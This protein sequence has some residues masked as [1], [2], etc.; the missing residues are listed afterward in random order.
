M[1]PININDLN[2]AQQDVEHIAE[3]A[4]SSATTATDRLG[5]SKQTIS[6]LIAS[7][8]VSVESAAEVV[9]A[10]IGYT[11]PVSYSGGLSL[12]SRT[13][14]VEYLGQVY[15]PKASNLPFT[16][17]GEFETAKFRLLAGV[18]GADLGT[19]G[20]AALVGFAQPS[21]VQRTV[22]DRLRDT[23]SVKDFGAKGDGDD[24]VAI[25]AAFDSA[26]A[27]TVTFPPGRYKISQPIYISKA[28]TVLMQGSASTIE[29]LSWGKPAFILNGIADVRFSGALRVE[30]LGI[31]TNPNVKPSSTDA[32]IQAEYDAV[33]VGNYRILCAAIYAR[34]QCDRLSIDEL[35]VRGMFA[36]LSI[37][38]K[39][40]D[41]L[42]DPDDITI[43]NMIFDTVDWGLLVGGGF[44]KITIGSIKAKNVTCIS[45]DPSHAI[46][47]GPRSAGVMN[48]FFSLGSL[49]VDGCAVVA[50]SDAQL[51]QG[52]AF[53][54][55]S[56]THAWIG[57]VKVRNSQA[58]G[59]TR[60]DASLRIDSLWADLLEYKAGAGGASQ[61]FA[62]SVQSGSKI[63]VGHVDVIARLRCDGLITMSVFQGSG[64]NSAMRM[65]GG[66][67]RLATAANPGTVG[68]FTSGADYQFTNLDMVFDADISSTLGDADRYALYFNGAVTG[69]PIIINPSIKG[70]KRLCTFSN[71][72]DHFMQ[73]DPNRYYSGSDAN[74]VFSTS[75][76]YRISFMSFQRTPTSLPAGVASAPWHGNNT[77][78]TANTGATTISNLPRGVDGQK[79]LLIQGDANTTVSHAPGLIV[80]KGAASLQPSQWKWIEFIRVSGVMYET[81]HG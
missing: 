47:I 22:Q 33:S 37:A 67:V 18:T 61:S 53:S 12:T 71:K 41:A 42:S 49:D 58:I 29:C 9:L 21:G 23:V 46:Y 55:R 27:K 3:I 60:N 64:A 75:G 65:D 74:T 30:Y 44:K 24:T 51:N 4:T 68:R 13:Q 17:S 34:L 39:A 35:S 76:E 79:Y 78:Q 5:R 72:P 25:Q 56:T 80:L 54:I 19:S 10:G 14:T 28:C 32:R 8:A 7:A 50:D 2:N 52:D 11:P 57:S 69:A 48:G 73:V 15:A 6:G 77:I 1:R 63:S 81:Q 36:G 43:G 66:R 45:G 38:G 59:N 40:T 70:T 31:R 26:N 16:T 62:L 20:G